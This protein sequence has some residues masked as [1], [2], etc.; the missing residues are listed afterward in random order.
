V[1][2]LGH[3]PS[4]AGAADE[5]F[6]SHRSTCPKSTKFSDSKSSPPSLSSI[7]LSAST[8]TVNSIDPN[9]IMDQL[10]IGLF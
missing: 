1:G 8:A 5:M 2:E 3:K 9:K 10:A 7:S 6:P 4:G